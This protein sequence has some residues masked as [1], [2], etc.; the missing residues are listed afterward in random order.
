MPDQAVPDANDHVAHT[1]DT[2]DLQQPVIRRQEL[3]EQYH[4]QPEHNV[5]GIV[6]VDLHEI[7]DT[8]LE[9]FI[10]L[11]S[12]RLVGSTLLMD[13]NYRIVGVEGETL[14]IDVSGDP[15][16]VV[17]DEPEPAVFNAVLTDLI[18]TYT[19]AELLAVPGVRAVLAENDHIRNLVV[20]QLEK[21]TAE[22]VQ[23][24]DVISTKPILAS[25]SL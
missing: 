7:I 12:E 17:D 22:D 20:A 15:S 21:A 9:G 14:L 6:R 2:L 16:M 10:D 25:Y 23:Q 11:C 8:D 4:N 3:V 19:I 24:P 5:S 1:Q 18:E 13:V